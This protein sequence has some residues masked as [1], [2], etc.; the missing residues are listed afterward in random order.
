MY[1]PL[2]HA[3]AW[4]TTGSGGARVVSAEPGRVERGGKIRHAHD[5]DAVDIGRRG[6]RNRG[7]EP[8]PG[9]LGEASREL[10]NLPYFAPETDLAD[11]HHAGGHGLLEA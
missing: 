9:R 6:G 7:G 2:F 3:T 4:T 5:P 1:Q 8:E 10:T 11:G